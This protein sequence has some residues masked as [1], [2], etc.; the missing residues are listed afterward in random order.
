MP[1]FLFH[2]E[3]VHFLYCFESHWT[4]T[5]LCSN[6]DDPGWKFSQTFFALASFCPRSSVAGDT[7]VCIAELGVDTVSEGMGRGS[8][9]SPTKFG[10]DKLASGFLVSS[11]EILSSVTS[12]SVA[13]SA[14][15]MKLNSDGLSPLTGRK[16]TNINVTILYYHYGKKWQRGFSGC[17]CIYCSASSG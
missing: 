14:S 17:T 12:V 6:R 16:L 10:A 9:A 1:T 7:G 15:Y 5:N 13:R 8:G 2:Y 11:E 4:T 3:K